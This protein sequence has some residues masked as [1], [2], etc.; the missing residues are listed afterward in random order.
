MHTDVLAAP[1]VG[2]ASER[3]PFLAE[4][5]TVHTITDAEEWLGLEAAWNETVDR[6]GITH[7]FVRHE[8]LRAWWQASKP[9]E[10]GP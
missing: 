4:P 3:S 9:P 6:S 5:C 1:L 2:A 10:D 8:W 7:P